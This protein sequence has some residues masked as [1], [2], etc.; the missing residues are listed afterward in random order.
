M[1]RKGES[2]G[3]VQELVDIKLDC[4]GDTFLVKVNQIGGRACHTGRRHCFFYH[5]EGD[6]WC[7]EEAV[8]TTIT[9]PEVSL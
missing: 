4:D 1:W 9:S 3:N 2:S 5:P 6:Q 8:S 7:I